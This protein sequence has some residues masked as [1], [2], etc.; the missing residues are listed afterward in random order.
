[1]VPHLEKAG[2][3]NGRVGSFRGLPGKDY[4]YEP[5]VDHAI[6]PGRGG[7]GILLVLTAPK[8]PGMY[9]VA[10]VQLD[11]RI[12]GTRYRSRIYTAV[13]GCVLEQGQ[14]DCPKKQSDAVWDATAKLAG[15]T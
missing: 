11:Y 5:L 4:A 3:I 2:Y 13:Y 15:Q 1:M 9:A 12:D 6:D 10:G 7:A 14:Q 8:R